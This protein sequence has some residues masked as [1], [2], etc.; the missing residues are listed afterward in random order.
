MAAT[1]QDHEKRHLL[2]SSCAAKL[3]TRLNELSWSDVGDICQAVAIFCLRKK[4]QKSLN[5]AP[6]KHRSLLDPNQ[7]VWFYQGIKWP[8][9][10]IV[11]NRI[12]TFEVQMITRSEKLVWQ[13]VMKWL[14]K[15][16]VDSRTPWCEYFVIFDYFG[17]LYRR[18][19]GNL[20]W[21]PH[22]KF[23]KAK[24]IKCATKVARF[25]SEDFYTKSY[26]KLT[27]FES[28]IVL[29]GLTFSVKPLELYQWN[30]AHFFI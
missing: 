11:M 6:F 20:L 17:S 26:T 18:S 5:T 22:K 19:R 15:F 25:F 3:F 2:D 14:L 28:A 8:A 1:R 27:V 12:N 21:K 16:G 24:W 30:L 10:C 4:R 23:K 29:A 13:H 7:T 9:S